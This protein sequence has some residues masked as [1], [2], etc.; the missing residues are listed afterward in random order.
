MRVSCMSAGIRCPMPRSGSI[1][2]AT[3]R[4]ASVSRTVGAIVPTHGVA[5]VSRTVR[6]SVA[7]GIG[8]GVTH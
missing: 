5:V 4:V 2:A 1:V 3:H 8:A 6:A 7:G